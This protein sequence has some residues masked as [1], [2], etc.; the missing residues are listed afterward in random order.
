MALGYEPKVAPNV[1]AVRKIVDITTD[2]SYAA[3]GYA[4]TARSC[5]VG[6]IDGLDWVGGSAGFVPVWNPA[7]SKLMFFKTGS[8]TSAA[9]LEA[10]N[11]EAGL[12]GVVWRFAVHGDQ[13]V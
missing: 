9:L 4:L 11:N 8:A 3:G 10:A 13:L 7:T 12:N 5:G 6:R 1:G 2:A